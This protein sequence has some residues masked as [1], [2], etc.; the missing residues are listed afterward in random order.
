MIL[1]RIVRL[2]RDPSVALALGAGVCATLWISPVAQAATELPPWRWGQ[3]SFG[4]SSTT[5]YFSTNANYDKTR[6]SFE[7]LPNGNSFSSFES[8]LRARYGLTRQWSIYGGLGFGY[9]RAVDPLYERTN[10]SVTDVFAGADFNLPLKWIR[11]IPE[12]QLG[13]PIYQLDPNTKTPLTSEGVGY[14]RATLFAHKAFKRIEFFG[15]GGIYIPAEGL[16]KRFVYGAGVDIPLGSVIAIGGGIEGYE[17][18]ISDELTA[19]E[20]AKL[21]TAA[22]VGSYRFHAYNPA[23]MEAQGWVRFRPDRSLM[24][25]AGYSKSING[26]RSA[27]GQSFLLTLTFNTPGSNR[28]SSREQKTGRVRHGRQDDLRTFEETEVESSDSSSFE[29]EDTSKDAV[30]NDLDEAERFLEKR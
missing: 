2:S 16:A 12:L 8:K 15:H 19:T 24:I 27:E 9:S 14:F 7:K 25:R 26:V 17:T 20:R 1:A 21:T 29:A 13:Y 18:A 4:L 3:G 11:L 30:G 10:S 6:G 28:S 22:D 23:L 5:E